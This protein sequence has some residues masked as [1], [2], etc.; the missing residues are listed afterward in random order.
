MS[1][2]ADPKSTRKNNSRV[3]P[4]VESQLLK[5]LKANQRAAQ[6]ARTAA[7]VAD[8]RELEFQDEVSDPPL[9]DFGV[10]A[11]GVQDSAASFGAE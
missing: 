6:E 2:S 9:V 11:L 7:L 3:G 1:S 4:P 5:E 10:T 8:Y